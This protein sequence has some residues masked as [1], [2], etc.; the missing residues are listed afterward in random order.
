MKSKVVALVILSFLMLTACK[1]KVH[2]CKL[3]RHYATDGTSTPAGGGDVFLYDASGRVTKVTYSSKSMDS[4]VRVADTLRVFNFDADYKLVSVLQ[5]VTNGFGYVTTATKTSYDISGAITGTENYLYE[6]N[7]EGRLT[8]KTTSTSGGTSILTLTYTGSNPTSGLLY[9]GVNL[10]KKYFFYHGTAENKSFIDDFN[11][12][13]TPYFGKP[14]AQLL[15]SA[16]VVLATTSDTLRVQYTHTLDAND[17]VNKTVE[18][19]LTPTVNTTYHT[20]Q[21]F[22]CKEQ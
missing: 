13:S 9:N 1:Q 14:S 22:D 2:N 8:Q 16:H 3:G 20:Y 17:Y 5:G 21:Y 12:V 18:S 15:D 6:Y 19:W 7:A 4:L 11:G 10:E